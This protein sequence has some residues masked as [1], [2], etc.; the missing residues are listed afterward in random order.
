MTL[1]SG[2]CRHTKGSDATSN[3]APDGAAGGGEIGAENAQG[4]ATLW[5][6]FCCHLAPL[7]LK[8][9]STLPRIV[10]VDSSF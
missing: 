10:E 5:Q 6:Q 2:K 4:V 9:L 1:R 7:R 3:Q 8:F